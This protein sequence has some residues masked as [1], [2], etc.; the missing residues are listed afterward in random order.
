M[1][2]STSIALQVFLVLLV[3]LYVIYVSSHKRAQRVEAF[4][5]QRRAN[6]VARI[7]GFDGSAADTMLSPADYAIY[8]DVIDNYN[9]VLDR[10]PLPDELFKHFN[11]IKKKSYN[12][13]K[14]K[15][16]LLGSEEH[17]RNERV[18]NNVP[19][20]DIDKSINEQ[21]LND[22]ITIAYMKENNNVVPSGATL[23]FLKEQYLLSGMN[24]DVLKVTIRKFMKDTVNKETYTSSTTAPTSSTTAPASS[25]T[26]P[27]SST[28]TP[29]SSSASSIAAA[30]ESDPNAVK[31][32]LEDT[33]LDDIDPEV[34]AELAHVSDKPF[35]ASA[36]AATLTKSK[37]PSTVSMVVE[38]PNIFNIYSQK[39]STEVGELGDMI[40][41]IVSGMNHNDVAV[42]KPAQTSEQ[43]TKF[44]AVSKY[45]P[46]PVTK[47]THNLVSKPKQTPQAISKNGNKYPIYDSEDPLNID[48]MTNA[49]LDK[50][51]MGANLDKRTENMLAD[52]KNTRNM[53]ELQFACDRAGGSC[54]TD[55]A[56]TSSSKAGT[57]G[58][59]YDKNITYR[60]TGLNGTDSDNN[61]NG[62]NPR[63]NMNSGRPIYNNAD[64]SG[65]LFPEY[66]WSVP[67]KRLPDAPDTM[68]GPIEQT[69]LI[70]TLLTDAQKTSSG[71]IIKKVPL[72][73]Y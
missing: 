22:K 9:K 14:L 27:T 1:K 64:N 69:A 3:V 71:S 44:Q 37:T 10:Q 43:E 23:A 53:S 58:T 33:N 54:A 32:I 45:A 60:S 11:A 66:A 34:G 65:K 40:S 36:A 31:G 55:A 18:Q 59:A 68:Y 61:K 4:E 21:Y 8:K 15:G 19:R 2:L 70:G 51:A 62:A 5:Q 13:D 17:D 20:E 39:A 48:N 29:T 30:A 7:E 57:S 42:T 35:I 72:D 73:D 63:M 24:D 38:R 47:S 28:T 67:Q 6:I 25:T 52:Y 12:A 56:N 16:I 49:C 41:N 46:K 26:T 50:N